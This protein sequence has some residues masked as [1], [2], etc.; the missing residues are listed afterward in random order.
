MG[1]VCAGD[2]LENWQY[3]WNKQEWPPPV[4]CLQVLVLEAAPCAVLLLTC[5]FYIIWLLRRTSRTHP[6]SI[7]FLAKI[8]LSVCLAALS[9]VHCIVLEHS[10]DHAYMAVRAARA[11]AAVANIVLVGLEHSRDQIRSPPLFVYW[12]V[13]TA[14]DALRLIMS[15]SKEEYS[16]DMGEF[17]IILLFFIVTTFIFI[18]NCISDCYGN[19]LVE[20]SPESEAS[21]LSWIT[22]TWFNRLVLRGYKKPLT[23]TDLYPMLSGDTSANVSKRFMANWDIK[24]MKRPEY[25]DLSEDAVKNQPGFFR[26]LLR[27]FQWE[28]FT[29]Q[30]GTLLLASSNLVTPIILG[31]L[32]GYS[33]DESEPSWHGYIYLAALVSVRLLGAVSDQATQFFCNRLAIRVRTAAVAAIFNKALRM[34]QNTKK[35]CSVGE[36][37]N[38]MSVD[39]KNLELFLVFSCMAW[40]GIFHLAFG[41]YLCY[42]FSGISMIT[43][44]VFI[45][46]M[47]AVNLLTNQ[48]VGTYQENLMKIGDQR[49]KLVGEVL[50]GIKVIK[51]HGWEPL[52]AKKIINLRLKELKVLLQITFFGILETFAFTASKFW[53]TFCILAA[54]VALRSSHHLDAKK[55]FLIINYINIINTAV[56]SLP[57]VV[58]LAFKMRISISRINEFL[59]TEDID[60]TDSS[61]DLDDPCALRITKSDFKWETSGPIILKDIE[62]QVMPGQ[63]VA[64]VGSVGAGKSSLLAAALGEMVKVGGYTNINSSVAHVPQEAWIQ[65]LSIRDN[66]LFGRD[67]DR[68]WYHSVVRACSLEPDLEMLPARDSTEIGEKG[69]NLSG[70]QKQ[71]V[72]L[73]RAVYSH[74]DIYLLDD[75]LSAVDSHVGKSIFQE[76]IGAQGLLKGKTR[77][78][79]TH[80]LQWLPHVDRI[81]VMDDGRIKETGTYTDLTVSKDGAFA[82]FVNK[83]I[84]STGQFNADTLQNKT[85]KEKKTIRSTDT[86]NDEDSI[87]Q[88]QERTVKHSNV[89]TADES[90]EEGQ[91]KWGVYFELFRAYGWKFFALTATLVFCFHSAFNA[92]YV[93][94]SAYTDDRHLGN[95]TELPPDSAGRRDRNRDHLLLL[96]YCGLAQTIFTLFYASIYQWR[97]VTTSRVL[98]LELLRGVMR[99]PISFFETTPT[100]RILNR[101]SQ[102]LD[103]LDSFVFFFLEICVEHGLFALGILT[104][105][106]YALPIMTAVTVPTAALV[107]FLQRFYSRSVCRLNRMASANRSP[108]FAHFSETVSGLS[109]IRA[110]CQQTRFTLDNEAK[111]DRFQNPAF[112]AYAANK[113]MQLWLDLLG[114]CLLLIVTVF[115]IVNRED[116]KPGLVGLSLSLVVAITTEL[117]AMSQKS[118]ELESNIVAVERI[119][120]YSRLSSEAPWFLPKDADPDG[121]K[122]LHPD[123]Q[124]SI[125][126]IFNNKDSP[127]KEPISKLPSSRGL[128]G[129][130]IQSESIVHLTK[131]ACI[132]SD[133]SIF[134]AVDSVSRKHFLTKFFAPKFR[135]GGVEEKR[136]QPATYGSVLGR[137][138]TGDK[139]GI[140]LNGTSTKISDSEKDWG[141]NG[142]S[143]TDI[144]AGTSSWPRNGQIQFVDFSCRYRKDTERVL[145]KINFVIKGGEKVGVVGRTGAGKSS[146]VLSLFRLVEADEGRILIDGVDI[147]S[148]GL[149]RLRRALTI[150]PQDPVLFAGSLRDNLD[151]AGE[152]SEG[153]LWKALERAHLRQFVQT[154]PKQLDTTVGDGGNNLSMGQR[155]LVCLARTLLCQTR[156]LVLDEATAA[157]DLE[158]DSLV[159]ATIH[160]AFTSCT[161]IAIA[162]RLS[163]ILDYDRILVLDHGRILEF[164]SPKVLMADPNSAFYSL[165]TEAGLV[166]PTHQDA[167]LSQTARRR[168]KET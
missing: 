167:N 5:P 155:Q 10:D 91:V 52:F 86:S 115:V 32:I 31:W 101:F 78:L 26:C 25:A 62:M 119:Q 17:F 63:L 97:H 46:V 87:R 160:S 123:L 69:I 144:D 162:H 126:E 113:W 105:I 38:L 28:I 79:V 154:L 164:D 60:E 131:S 152:R 8:V 83:F 7:K 145:K 23:D 53:M 50:E 29:S 73:A 64:I 116:V 106:S 85:S 122:S 19:L 13:S 111:V 148:L 22:F 66:I 35:G 149:H 56:L 142:V 103:S 72:S 129:S 55:A 128:F 138:G 82:K 54:F 139:N 99:A 127:K 135:A 166:L 133:H 27:T 168:S 104:V 59:Q 68:T 146:L 12:L 95:F 109:V 134:P 125:F 84:A 41:A 21:S 153:E 161:V 136:Q 33:S 14:N 36:I 130:R 77:I 90:L 43:G 57:L 4:S 141:S 49:L 51:L 140:T 3:A 137:N 71:R 92:F 159:Q 47:L 76:V 112:L 157:V 150:L 132:N 37:V 74:A 48:K 110:Q 80:G 107:Y 143:S 65:N 124:N 34:R 89:L 120:E 40:S 15:I 81:Y 108:V 24:V 163:T 67:L 9:V 88:S 117:K 11:L 20:I 100:G 93:L 58:K 158:T 156:V 118:S 6:I 42:T 147:S 121:E 114:C 98:H 75:P 102:D 70:G 30:C 39:T 96:A 45:V 1:K 16:H 94:L 165:A 44:L 61:R 151:P 2:L 18:L